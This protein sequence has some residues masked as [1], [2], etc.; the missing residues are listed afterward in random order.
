MCDD[1]C[2]MRLVKSA[3]QQTERMSSASD[4]SVSLGVDDATRG[5]AG[6]G[7]GVMMSSGGG[8]DES[9]INVKCMGKKL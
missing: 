3:L 1:I 9:E 5:V 7:E 8:A 4:T 6:M 2:G